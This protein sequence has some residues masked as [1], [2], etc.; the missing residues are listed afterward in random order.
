MDAS[1]R[2]MVEGFFDHLAH[3]HSEHANCVR[4]FPPLSGYESEGRVPV[5]GA[6]LTERLLRTLQR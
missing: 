5:V 4:M 6:Y 1:D 3:I 2:D